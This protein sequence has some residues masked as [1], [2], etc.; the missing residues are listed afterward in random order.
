MAE[1]E[2]VLSGE[3]GHLHRCF[4]SINVILLEMNVSALCF[5]FSVSVTDTLKIFYFSNFK[6]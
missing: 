4:H 1:R 3:T 2:A 6:V 5:I